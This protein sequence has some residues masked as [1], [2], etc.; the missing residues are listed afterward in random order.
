[1]SQFFKMVWDMHK[2]IPL[3]HLAGNIVWFSS[4]FLRKKVPYM[5]KNAVGKA[6]DIRK[7]QAAYVKELDNNIARCVLGV[8]D[9]MWCL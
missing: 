6:A 3:I 8:C 9:A 5:V 4:D 1:M 7:Q 2:S